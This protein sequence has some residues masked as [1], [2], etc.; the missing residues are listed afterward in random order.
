M[1]WVL[2]HTT[3]KWPQLRKITVNW[4]DIGPNLK[5]YS[6]LIKVRVYLVRVLGR[7][8][9]PFLF[10]M[11]RGCTPRSAGK[12]RNITWTFPMIWQLTRTFFVWKVSCT[13]LHN[14]LFYVFF[15]IGTKSLVQR[16]YKHC[17]TQLAVPKLGHSTRLCHCS[18]LWWVILSNKRMPVVGCSFQQR[19]CKVLPSCS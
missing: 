15:K 12:I 10:S 8:K 19:S 13:Q 1:T 18:T 6:E 16:S 14:F 9:P 5:E 2:R 17:M 11:A 3:S 7:A 4:L